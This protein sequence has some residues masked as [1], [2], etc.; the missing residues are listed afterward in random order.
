MKTD[1]ELIAEFMG[2]PKLK[3][4]KGDLFD[5]QGTGREI[6]CIREYELHYRT[7]WDWLMPVIQKIAEY[8]YES[9]NDSNGYKD[10]IVHDRAYPRT[11]GMMDNEGKWMVR[12]NR[13]HLEQEN[14]L[15]EAAYKS[16]IEFIKWYNEK[17][18]GE[19][20]S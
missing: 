20:K 9:Y 1:N 2:M 12:I 5:F 6:Y 15:I 3:D 18:Q 14:T 16:V 7:S 19:I 11:F 10:V 17:H 13:Q 4:S 8:T